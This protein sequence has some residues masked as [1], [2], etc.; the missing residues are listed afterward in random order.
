M[1]LCAVFGLPALLV[2]IT[3]VI[4]PATAG[5]DIPDR[6]AYLTQ[7]AKAGPE[8][9]VARNF[10]AT[11]AAPSRFFDESSLVGPAAPA[12]V[13]WLGRAHEHCT[14]P[15]TSVELECQTRGLVDA[16]QMVYVDSPDRAR[17]WAIVTLHTSPDEGNVGYER[18]LLFKKAAGGYAFHAV[19][20][21]RGY[22]PCHFA[23]DNGSM[24][25]VGFIGTSGEAI[26]GKGPR[27]RFRIV[28]EGE[29]A[30]VVEDGP[31]HRSD[32]PQA[33]ETTA[34]ATAGA[35]EAMETVRAIYRGPDV[36]GV[37]ASRDL[38]K[39][40]ASLTPAFIAF[41]KSPVTS[42]MEADGDPLTWS[43]MTDSVS[44]GAMTPRD[45]VGDHGKIDATVNVV[46]E[47]R[48]KTEHIIWSMR[49]IAGRWLADDNSFNGKSLRALLRSL[50]HPLKAERSTTTSE[51]AAVG[52]VGGTSDY[53]ADH[54]GSEVMVSPATGTI[55]YF[56][57]KASMAGIV[58][59][60]ATLFR[61][62][63]GKNAVSGTAYVFRRGCSPA[64][65]AVTGVGYTGPGS[66]FV[67]VGHPPIRASG[68]CSIIG[69]GDNGNSVLHFDPDQDGDM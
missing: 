65:Y 21:A 37:F 66:G 10:L 27:Q 11:A 64:P 47:G 30:K 4:T 60:G 46:V 7:A 34:P 57:P 14:P 28:G 8:E 55:H 53:L 3:G 18:I 39:L 56:R 58:S 15:G 31:T 61:G 23:D 48:P 67:L 9:I 42:T 44:L 50:Y 43:Q 52:I 6:T 25:Y 45:F 13:A 1:R 22:Q 5:P 49:R 62:S 16:A 35:D 68:S 69:Y 59:P 36:Y 41:W 54:N 19:A 32:A 29:A 20:D 51:A 2:G 24:T 40:R 17:E 63:F 33:L 12:V 38:K 26:E